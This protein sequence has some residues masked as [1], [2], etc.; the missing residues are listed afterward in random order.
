MST[1]L[2]RLTAPMQSWGV[3]VRYDVCSTRREPT[4]SGI[5]GLVASALGIARDDETALSPL[6]ALK[7]GVRVD[8]EGTLLRDYHTVRGAKSAHVTQRYYLADALFLVG[9]SGTDDL[10]ADIAKAIAAPAYPLFLGRRSCPPEGQVLLGIRPES[11]EDA[12]RAE[13]WLQPGWRQ[14]N[15]E[16]NLRLILD[17]DAPGA[18]VQRDLPLSYNPQLRSYGFRGVRESVIPMKPRP[19]YGVAHD[20]MAELEVQA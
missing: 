8:R 9:L 16:R 18:A 10:L 12:L 20:P 15:A 19:K 6:R 13:P 4:K 14:D 11:L 17:S 5:I 1:L 2:L 7:M 3:E